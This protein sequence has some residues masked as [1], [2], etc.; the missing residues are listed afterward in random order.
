MYSILIKTVSK[1]YVYDA[2]EES[3]TPTYTWV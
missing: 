2:S 1:T 3:G